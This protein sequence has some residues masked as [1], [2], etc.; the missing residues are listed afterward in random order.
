ME[1][2]DQEKLDEII[3]RVVDVAEPEKQSVTDQDYREALEI[4][5]GVRWAEEETVGQP[6]VR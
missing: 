3:R 1:V 4:A 2:V 6:R 5:K